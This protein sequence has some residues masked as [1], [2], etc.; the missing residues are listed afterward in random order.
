MKKESTAFLKKTIKVWQPY[1][2]RRLTLEDARQIQENVTGFF[3]ILLEWEKNEK[4][5]NF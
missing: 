3:N 2:K 4:T 5:Q 1:Y